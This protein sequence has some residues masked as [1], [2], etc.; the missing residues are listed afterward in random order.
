MINAILKA[1]FGTKSQRDLKKMI[2]LVKKINDY[3]ATK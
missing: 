3:L 2:P 1:L